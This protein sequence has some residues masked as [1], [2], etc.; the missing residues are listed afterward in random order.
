[1]SKL[2]DS[3]LYLETTRKNI[4]KE[5]FKTILQW[6]KDRIILY[7]GT[8]K[9][10]CVYNIPTWIPGKPLFDRKKATNYV[11]KKLIREGMTVEIIKEHQL[12]ISWPK[13]QSQPPVRSPHPPQESDPFEQLDCLVNKLSLR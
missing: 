1:M 2:I 10:Y 4:R 9:K 12:Y 11:R 3:V 13:P 7:A 6:V 5:T 8:H